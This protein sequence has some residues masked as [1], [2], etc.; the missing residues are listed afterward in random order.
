[1]NIV[2]VWAWWT[3]ISTIAFI[4]KDLWYNNIICID[5]K[6][7]EITKKIKDYWI[8]IIIW[9]WKYSIQKEDLVIYSDA[10]INS[11][12]VIDANNIDKS[13]KKYNKTYSYFEFIWE[14]SKYYKTISI[15]GTHWKSSTTSMTSYLLKELKNEKFWLA[16]VWANIPQLW[17]KNYYI[18][19][20]KKHFLDKCIKNIISNKSVDLEYDQIKSN[21]LI[22]EADEYN[23]HFL[24]FDTDI[25]AITNIELDH[26]D[27]YWDFNNYISTFNEFTSKVREKIFVLSNKKENNYIKKNK[28]K[29]EIVNPLN[30]EFE[31][32]WWKHNQENWSLALEIVNYLSD[33]NKE[34]I[35][36]ELTKFKWVWR[37]AEYLFSNEK[38]TE[39]YS[40]YWHHPSELKTTI[41]G[42]K[43]KFK[44]KNIKIIFQPHQARRLIEFWT[45]FINCLKWEDIIIYDLYTAREDIEKIAKDNKLDIKSKKELGDK[46]AELINWNYYENFDMIENII[47]ETNNNEVILVFSAWDLDWKIRNINI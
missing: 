4:L 46:F 47:N 37:R 44:G 31:F 3:G 40:D 9:H 22:V 29:L 13:F 7:S 6:E 14:I 45:D 11:K 8:Q 39:I 25:A 16:L 41:D 20:D 5:S 38:W 18:N 15:A 24:Q 2:I 36:K 35:I 28:E 17:N 33:F 12:E 10:A 34:E 21:Y 19:K 43:D 42:F 32:L 30:I 1:M 26:S 27:V 23:K